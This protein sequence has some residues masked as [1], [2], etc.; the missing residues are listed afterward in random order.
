M[1]YSASRQSLGAERRALD[2]SVWGRG[3]V[4]VVAF[5]A[6]CNY[7]AA[8]VPT[9]SPLAFSRPSTSTILLIFSPSGQ[10]T[11]TGAKKTQNQ[12]YSSLINALS[13]VAPARLVWMASWLEAPFAPMHSL[14]HLLLLHET[15]TRTHA[16]Y[17]ARKQSSVSQGERERERERESERES[18][19]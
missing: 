19:A 10:L 9:G 18:R 8:S 17:E 15:D 12:S 16:L 5:D 3:R 14:A 6:C 2:A 7:S 13:C 1:G 4:N 11:R